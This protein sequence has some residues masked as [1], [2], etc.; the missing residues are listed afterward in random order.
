MLKVKIEGGNSVK[1]VFKQVL[2][3]SL[4]IV[5]Y[6]AITITSRF[7]YGYITYKPKQRYNAPK[8]YSKME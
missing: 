1:Q 6:K 8:D 3:V 7:I 5:T 4:T 2:Q